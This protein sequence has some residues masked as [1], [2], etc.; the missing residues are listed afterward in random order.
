MT[1]SELEALIAQSIQDFKNKVDW[2][3]SG[4]IVAIYDG[5]VR[6]SGLYSVFFNEVVIFSNDMAGIVISLEKDSLLVAV[7]GNYR[8]L[9]ADTIVLRTHQQAHVKAS[10]E[11]LT[12]ILDGCG[13]PIDKGGPIINGQLMPIDNDAMPMMHR[14]AVNRQLVTGIRCIDWLLPIGFGQRQAI[15]GGRGA[16]K[17]SIITDI[18]I[19]QKDVKN[20]ISIYVSIGQRINNARNVQALL[21]ENGVK[22][23]IIINSLS[24]D[25]APSRYLAPFTAMAI[26]EYFMQQGKNAIV[27]FDSLTQHAFAYREM[28]LIMRRAPGREA[29]PGDIFYQHAKLLERAAKAHENFGGGSITAFP[30]VETIYDDISYIATNIMSITDGQIFLKNELA[31]LNIRPAI[32]IKISVSR[33]GGAV[34]LPILKKKIS[35]MKADIARGQEYAEICGLSQEVDDQTYKIVEKGKFFEKLLLQKKNTPMK[36]WHQILLLHLAVNGLIAIDDIE[37]AILMTASYGEYED[38][39]LKGNLQVIDNITKEII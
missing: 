23:Y 26:A 14:S 31:A 32:N 15:L 36:M 13:N 12:R 3:D 39:I 10:E 21:E 38:E 35:C 22:N 19:S 20:T 34:Q 17:T 30:V 37:K 8:L 11:L 4:K 5:I 16:G 25:P 7:L 1:T 18:I 29:Y 2:E 9:K 33:I 28:S 6:V 24:S 27:Y